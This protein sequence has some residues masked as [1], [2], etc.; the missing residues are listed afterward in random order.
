MP[1]GDSRPA[2]VVSRR[3]LDALTA[4][5]NESSQLPALAAAFQGAASSESESVRMRVACV[6]V[7]CLFELGKATEA[8]GEIAQMY[9][10]S[11]DLRSPEKDSSFSTL[12]A[13]VP[14]AGNV[15]SLC[16]ISFHY[17]HACKMRV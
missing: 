14:S 8:F 1:A 7:Q 16:S 2:T 3:F 4:A 5:K 12:P 6:V 11:E 15:S 9:S 13:S 10:V 17:F